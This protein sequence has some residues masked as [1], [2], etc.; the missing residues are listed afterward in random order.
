MLNLIFQK[1]RELEDNGN[2]CSFHWIPSHSGLIRNEKADLATKNR[3]EKGGELIEQSSLLEYVR[4]N[5][6]EIR[7]KSIA[8]W[9]KTET[10]EGKISRRGYYIP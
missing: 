4:K 5:V 3:A 9:H 6:T 7:S 1:T 2:R 10:Q 8:R